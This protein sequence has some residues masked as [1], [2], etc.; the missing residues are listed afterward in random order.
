MHRLLK[1]VGVLREM[2]SAG[3]A[4]TISIALRIALRVCDSQTDVV[5]LTREASPKSLRQRP[6]SPRQRLCESLTPR[7]LMTDRKG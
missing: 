2:S 5:R 7:I 6:L 1:N 4:L 3:M